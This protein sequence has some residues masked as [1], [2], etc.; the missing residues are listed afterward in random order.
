MCASAAPRAEGRK[1]RCTPRLRRVH[2]SAT[3]CHACLC[4]PLWIAT[5]GPQCHLSSPHVLHSEVLW[6]GR[7][8]NLFVTLPFI[9]PAHHGAEDAAGHRFDLRDRPVRGLR[10]ERSILPICRLVCPK[11]CLQLVP[12]QDFLRGLLP[13][14]GIRRSLQLPQEP[15]YLCPIFGLMGLGRLPKQGSPAGRSL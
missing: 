12:D 11:C 5:R 8:S 6:T 15:L 13:W 9:D 2:L 10:S 14:G 3:A 4:S 1:H 7:H